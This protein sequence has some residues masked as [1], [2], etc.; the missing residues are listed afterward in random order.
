MPKH[1]HQRKH[2]RQA[3]DQVALDARLVDNIHIMILDNQTVLLATINAPYRDYREA[4]GLVSA[5]RAGDIKIGQVSSSFF[6]EIGIPD[7]RSFAKVH[8][9]SDGVL[10]SAADMF[11]K[12][13]GQ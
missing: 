2:N 9:I 1:S 4:A 3:S 12:W 8:G 6:S 11:S 5:I 13:S 7:Q 10:V